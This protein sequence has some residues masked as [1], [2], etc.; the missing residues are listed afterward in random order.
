[1]TNNFDATNLRSAI[2][3]A[4]QDIAQV[5]ERGMAMNEA[6][7]EM[8]VIDKFLSALGY[9]PWDIHKQSVVDG[10]GNIPDYTILPNTEQQW[11]LEVKKWRLP[12]T[13]KEASQTVTY[14][15]NQGKRW[16]VLT[17]G[18]EWRVFDAYSN[19][20]LTQKC[21][22]SLPSISH[23]DAILFFEL[24]AK[25]SMMENKLAAF[26]RTRIIHEAVI[27]ELSDI[28]SNV[29]KKLGKEVE[30]KTG[31][32]AIK[33]EEIF[34]VLSSLVGCTQTTVIAVQ[35]SDP[36]T[37]KSA[38]NESAPSL[39]ELAQKTISPTYQNP[40]AVIFPDETETAVN[41]GNWRDV[42]TA[43]LTWVL[44]HHQM[45]ELPFRNGT[46]GHSDKYF[47]NFEPIHPDG[48]PWDAQRLIEVGGK[49]VYIYV[50]SSAYGLCRRMLD[51]VEAVGEDPSLIHIRMG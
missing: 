40:M 22:M 1:M 25:A 51:V 36:I 3:V 21:I 44:N 2:S 8:I 10:I 23:P 14:A 29:I 47:L 18:D 26:Y 37:S 15:S 11:F 4:I 35:T 24:L 12:L 16:A 17:N 19:G 38:I 9:N 45:P 32:A 42:T 7:T 49:N 6:M 50:H 30:V 34:T 43:V 27:A 28:S 33:K 20:H 5:D 41:K 48:T 13:P 39:L 31:L 46:P